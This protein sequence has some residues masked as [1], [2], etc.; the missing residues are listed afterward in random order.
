MRH[1]AVCTNGKVTVWNFGH[2]RRSYTFKHECT[3]V[4]TEMSPDG[5]QLITIAADKAW[6]EVIWRLDD[7]LLVWCISHMHVW[8]AC[9]TPDSKGVLLSGE[10]GVEE[11]DTASRG[12]CW[13]VGRTAILLKPSAWPTLTGPPPLGCEGAPRG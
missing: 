5:L 6:L 8:I 3:V 9:F 2:D 7:D 4:S 12:R 10:N 1:R 11:R 13:R